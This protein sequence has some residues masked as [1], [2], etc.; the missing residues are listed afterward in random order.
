MIFIEW[1][2]CGGCRWDDSDDVFSGDGVRFP[3]RLCVKKVEFVSLEIGD[4]GVE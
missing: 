2:F 3:A 4:D 1:E